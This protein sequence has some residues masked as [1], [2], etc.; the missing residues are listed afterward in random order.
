MRGMQPPTQPEAICVNTNQLAFYSGWTA[1]SN[2]FRYG[3]N[4]A[5]SVAIVCIW[6]RILLARSLM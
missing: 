3:Q 5:T 2:C 6:S 1:V 4:Y